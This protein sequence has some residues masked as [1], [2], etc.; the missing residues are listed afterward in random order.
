MMR[1]DLGLGP[2]RSDYRAHFAEATQSRR[3]WMNAA[4]EDY[5][6]RS[7]LTFARCREARS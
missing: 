5:F 7:G 4:A 3:I 2:S 1:E 6:G